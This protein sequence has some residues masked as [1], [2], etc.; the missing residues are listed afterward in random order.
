MRYL[1]KCGTFFLLIYLLFS[2]AYHNEEEL[3]GNEAINPCDTVTV[4]YTLDV[5]PVLQTTCYPC[6]NQAAA[7]GGV[8]LE[9]YNQAKAIAGSGRLLG[10]IS[11]S[12]GFTPMPKDGA[13][14]PSCDITKI[15][16]WI[17]AGMPEN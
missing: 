2:C 13:K 14:L 16:R 9:G 6:H 3:Y 8:I 11:H 4:T 1:F 5:L 7:S 17:E 12:P 15:S 10:A